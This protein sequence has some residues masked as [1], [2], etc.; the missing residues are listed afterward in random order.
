MLTLDY[1]RPEKKLYHKIRIY[2][3]I[4][5]AMRVTLS[6]GDNPRDPELSQVLFNIL[7][8]IIS[9]PCQIIFFLQLDLFLVFFVDVKHFMTNLKKGIFDSY[10]LLYL[11]IYFVYSAF[12]FNYLINDDWQ[13]FEGRDIGSFSNV[14]NPYLYALHS[15]KTF[16]IVDLKVTYRFILSNLALLFLMV[17]YI[18]NKIKLYSSKI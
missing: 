3:F 6:F 16:Q 2:F 13:H 12:V 7:F 11:L 1:F 8:G 9:L 14:I 4:I 17:Y 10:L 5:M 15:L 18:S